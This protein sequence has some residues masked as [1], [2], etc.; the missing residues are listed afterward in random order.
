MN[1]KKNKDFESEIIGDL[2]GDDKTTPIKPPDTE[3]TLGL[4]E[5][6]VTSQSSV[7]PQTSPPARVS[8]TKV[9]TSVGGRFALRPSTS[10][11]ALNSEAA[12]IQSENIRIAQQRIFELEQEIE[13][14]R[15]ENEQLAAAGE[16]IRQ[17]SDELQADNEFKSRKLGDIKERLESEKDIIENS[18]KAKDR[19]LKETQMKILEFEK[20]LSTNLQKIRV[21]ERELEN[22]LELIKME[23]AAVIRSK[24]EM[25]LD[26]KRQIDQ[27]ANELEN[28]RIKGQELNRQINDKQES[29]RR[30]VK[31]LRLALSL[32]EGGAEDQDL[33]KKAK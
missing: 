2:L 21:R 15:I 7:S 10:S 32:L 20:R 11:S 31:A 29:L 25:I 30:T 3:E 19:E 24:D 22:R 16:T 26:L 8:E 27:K 6:K 5:S 13:R 23:S 4:V 28:Y 14:L 12:L 9:R 18:L 33:L 17:R 1:A